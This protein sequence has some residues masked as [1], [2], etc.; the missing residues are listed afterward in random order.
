MNIIYSLYDES[1]Y[2]VEI[3]AF[4]FETEPQVVMNEIQRWAF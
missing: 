4:Y 1:D 2:A 3:E